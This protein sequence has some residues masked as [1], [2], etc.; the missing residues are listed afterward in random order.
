MITKWLEFIRQ[1]A[2]AKGMVTG[3]RKI[4]F[5]QHFELTWDELVSCPLDYTDIGYTK[6]KGR[7]LE[8][9]YWPVQ[10]IEA[11]FAKLASR[12]SKPHSSVAV[13]LKNG[14]KD[15]RSQGRCL[16]NMVITQTPHHLQVTILYR[17]T[18]LIQKFLADLIFFSQKLP[19]YFPDRKPTH[20]K[21]YF[22]NTYLSAVF[23]P[24]LM[25]YDPT[26]LGTLRAIRSGDPKF[27]RTFGLSTRRNFNPEC[28]YAYRT[29]VK[30][31]QFGWDHVGVTS[32][33]M[34]PVVA[35]L[36]GLT[37]EVVDEPEPD[38]L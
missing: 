19:A 5:D 25:R 37:G 11:A 8:R 20:I 18:E 21:F 9:I 2:C 33:K 7:Q 24:I 30:M 36:A 28:V 17:S 13:Q 32:K 14:I 12:T 31:W 15:S 1:V 29:R 23:A 27:F 3:V 10:D 16:Q 22:A 4:V 35:L 26:P 34:L 38:E 6:S